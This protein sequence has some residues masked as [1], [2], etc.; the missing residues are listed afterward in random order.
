MKRRK[1]ITLIGG[2]A[3]A[4]PLAVVAQQPQQSPV[5]VGVLPLGSVSNP[6][7]QALLAAFRRG[8][9]EV[10]L[11]ENR[12]VVLDIV[13]VESELEFPQAVSALMQRG[14]KLLVPSGTIASLEVKRQASTVPV[15]FI[16]VGNPVGIGLVESLSHPGGNVTGFSDMHA[17]LSGKYVQFAI[18]VGK[19]QAAVNYLWYPGWADGRYRLEVA[20]RA[21]QSLGVKIRSRAISDVAEAND[22]FGAMK[23]DGADVVVVQSSP[24]TFRYRDQLINSAMSRGLAT[25]FAFPATARAGALIGYGPDY[26]DLYRRAA[27]YVE[28]LIK[29]AKPSDLPVEQP[30]KFDMVINMKSAKTLGLTVPSTLLATA[31]EVIE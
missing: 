6:Y 24:F 13:W 25:I 3:V 16:N 11:V 2:A 8:L 20:E 23:A 17:D 12:H 18:E 5:R 15:L 9:R 21:A 7:N 27:S 14:P 31:T 10:G 1:F 30:T 29:G 28:R 26:E 19:P 22:I 4:W